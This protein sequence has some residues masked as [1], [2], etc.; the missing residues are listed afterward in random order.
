MA[1]SFQLSSYNNVPH[2]FVQLIRAHAAVVIALAVGIVIGATLPSPV[3]KHHIAQLADRPSI[4]PSTSIAGP[5]ETAT[6]EASTTTAAPSSPSVPAPAT[7]PVVPSG[8]GMWIWQPE[9]VEGGDPAG[10]V[11]RAQ[12]NGLTH[13][14]VRMGSSVDGFTGGPFLDALLPVA[15]AGGLRIIGWDFPYLDDVGADVDRALQAI[16]YV[17]PSGDRLDGFSAD[18]ETPQEYVALTAES[19]AMYGAGLRGRVGP[20][21]LLI[22][23]VPRPSPSRQADY[24]YPE[25]VTSF[26][27]IAPMVYW[28]DQPPDVEAANAVDF[29]SQ[30]GKPVLPIG[31]AYDGGLEGGP[32][33]TP[34]A[35]EISSFVNAADAA[36]AAG[37][38]FWSW[39]H[40][41]DEMWG[42]IA[43]APNV[44]V[45]PPG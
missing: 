24:P 23:T 21:Y 8:K 20:S 37:V 2:E 4:A 44:G 35:D 22:A 36:G 12:A 11:A 17:T 40:A 1:L 41:S 18:V 14:Y 29:L 34:T 3:A 33:G 15:H 45:K 43:S 25:V 10:I 7:A 28:I 6:T 19:A 32:P 30:Y 38:S 9:Y 27:A 5:P 13:L 16:W 42:A 39:Q 31:Q 26:D